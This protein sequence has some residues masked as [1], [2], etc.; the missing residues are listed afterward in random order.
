MQTKNKNICWEGSLTK[1]KYLGKNKN[2]SE[3]WHNFSISPPQ[4]L[5]W[6][7]P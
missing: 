4:D 1:M 3:D 6:N 5:K 7:S 2:I